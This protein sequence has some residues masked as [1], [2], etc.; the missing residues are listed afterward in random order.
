MYDKARPNE[1]E[2]NKLT[3][4]YTTA[5]ITVTS[6]NIVVAPTFNDIRLK[7]RTWNTRSVGNFD[8][9]KRSDQ[10]Y[11][12]TYPR[13]DTHAHKRERARTFALN[14][15]F[16]VPQ[17]IRVQTINTCTRT[18]TTRVYA[19]FVYGVGRSHDHRGW[20]ERRGERAVEIYKLTVRQMDRKTNRFQKLHPSKVSNKSIYT[21]GRVVIMATPWK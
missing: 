12:S 18:R 6:R 7:F 1:I 11:F 8:G 13:V 19:R 3:A 2:R 5:A 21:L 20:T 17:Y 9:Q 4:G 14:I 15:H 16:Y 10:T